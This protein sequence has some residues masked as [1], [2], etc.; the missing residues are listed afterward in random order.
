MRSGP[1]IKHG[2]TGSKIYY[3]WTGLRSRCNNPNNPRYK[4]YGK[5]G[6]K[7][8]VRWDS[9]ENFLKD[10]GPPPSSKHSLDRINNNKGYS[11]K[12]CRWALP[13]EQYANTRRNHF[14]TFKG[15]TFHIAEWARRVRMKKSALRHRINAGWTVEKALSIPTNRHNSN[16][17]GDSLESRKHT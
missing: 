16:F 2:L 15:K 17:G 6:I 5:R 10:M 12:N 14:I 7:V 1:K 8:C 13:K 11:P 3:R 4:D 9:F